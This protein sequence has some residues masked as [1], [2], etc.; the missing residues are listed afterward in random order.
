MTSFKIGAAAVGGL[1]L[2]AAIAIGFWAFRVATS[3]VKGSGDAEIRKNSATNRIAAQER[4]EQLHAEIIASDQ[5]IDVLADAVKAD[6]SYTNQ[7]NL[8]GAT[9]FCLSVVAD[10]NAEAR[11]FTAQ[12]FRAADLPAQI[13]A[14]DPATDCKGTLR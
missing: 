8:T 12:E 9:T 7:T 14:I 11:K 5:R 6:P 13:D 10:Y 1:V 4:F 3:D 2:I